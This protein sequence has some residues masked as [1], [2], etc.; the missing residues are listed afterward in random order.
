[1]KLFE[2][3]L[4]IFLATLFYGVLGTVTSFMALLLWSGLGFENI[5]N[6]TAVIAV[7]VTLI[8]ASV[9]VMRKFA[10]AVISAFAPSGW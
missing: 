7:T 2:L 10:V 1:M 3:M 5:L 9:P 8:G 4:D 6:L